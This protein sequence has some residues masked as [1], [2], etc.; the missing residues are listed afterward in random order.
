MLNGIQINGLPTKSDC[1]RARAQVEAIKVSVYRCNIYYTCSPCVGTDM[2]GYNLMVGTSSNQ[3][4]LNQG[5]EVRNGIQDYNYMREVQGMQS[6]F[7]MIVWKGNIDYSQTLDSIVRRNIQQQQLSGVTMSLRRMIPNVENSIRNTA[8]SLMGKFDSGQCSDNGLASSL[9][10]EFARLTGV[11]VGDYINKTDLTYEDQEIIRCYHDF[12]DEVLTRMQ[13]E[14]ARNPK[15]NDKSLEMAIYAL[16]VY[17]D[18]NSRPYDSWCHPLGDVSEIPTPSERDAAQQVLDFLTENNNKADFQADFYYDRNQDRYVL[19]FRG[20]ESK[21]QDLLKDWREDGTYLITGRSTQHDMAAALGEL[22]KNSGLPLDKLTITGHSLGGGLA[23]L[24]GAKSGAETYV[25]DPLHLNTKAMQNYS[26]SSDD[27]DNIHC[28]QEKNEGLVKLGETVSN[29]VNYVL[30][31]YASQG[32]RID[33]HNAP[34]E[35]GQTTIIEIPEKGIVSRRFEG[36][37]E[38]FNHSQKQLIEGV[39]ASLGAKFNDFLHGK[40]MQAGMARMRV[41]KPYQQ[42]TSTIKIKREEGLIIGS[43]R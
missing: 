28:F 5:V 43:V 10:D 7:D 13:Y 22:I 18:D 15:Y 38:F 12:C 29:A 8:M 20:T 4:V 36:A 40:N 21:L 9:K 23:L 11:N 14:Y 26:L 27:T 33:E 1:E 3:P 34:V 6:S 35:I 39:G 17:D 42:G 31:G 19:S 41:E 25:Y 2:S 32:G 37:T 24:A 16:H 30:E